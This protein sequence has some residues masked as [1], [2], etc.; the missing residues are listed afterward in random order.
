MQEQLD[1]LLEFNNSFD[2]KYS[3]KPTLIPIEEYTL[4]YNLMKEETDEYLSACASGNIVEIADALADQLYILCGTITA[5]GMQGIIEDIFA[6]VHRSNMSKLG[7]D[8]K[9]ILRED[10]KILK[11][12]NY[13]KPNIKQFINKARV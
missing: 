10:G 6:E 12:D 11:G 13:F 2:V 5:H 4:R 1:S 8:G 7:E 3:V 9:P